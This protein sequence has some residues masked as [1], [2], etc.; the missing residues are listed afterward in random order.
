MAEDA[1]SELV[2][3][4]LLSR[5]GLLASVDTVCPSPKTNF[6]FFHTNTLTTAHLRR[7]QA[8]DLARLGPRDTVLVHAGAGGVGSLAIQVGAWGGL[9]GGPG[10]S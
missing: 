2:R 1:G 4:C 5:A 9:R 7:I 3:C 8:L 6:T 10:P